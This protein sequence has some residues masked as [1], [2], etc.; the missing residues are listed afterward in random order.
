MGSSGSRLTAFIDLGFQRVISDL[1]GIMPRKETLQMT[2]PYLGQIQIELT[3][4][5]SPN[6]WQ[7]SKPSLVKSSSMN[8]RGS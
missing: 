7:D 8:G 2:W 4:S 3:D 1:F 5:D 6:C